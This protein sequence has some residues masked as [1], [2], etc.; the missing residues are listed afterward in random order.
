[1]QNNFKTQKETVNTWQGTRDRKQTWNRT[2]QNPMGNTATS[3]FKGP[4]FEFKCSLL[5]CASHFT[6]SLHVGVLQRSSL[7][8]RI[9]RLSV[10]LP[11]THSFLAMSLT[12][13]VVQSKERCPINA[14]P[15]AVSS[16]VLQKKVS[17][18]CGVQQ[19]SLSLSVTSGGVAFLCAP[20]RHRCR[21]LLAQSELLSGI[22][23]HPCCLSARNVYVS[24]TVPFAVSVTARVP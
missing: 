4:G 1:M 10:A 5:V 18:R 23:S 2:W 21:A 20:L 19:T 15:G 13:K 11:D 14:S 3:Q 9:L 16:F 24:A 7:F 17:Q 12:C 8:I 22:L 6:C